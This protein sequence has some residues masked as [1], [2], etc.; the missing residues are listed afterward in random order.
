M[1]WRKKRGSGSSAIWHFV[2]VW[3][4]H[5][6]FIASE[7]NEHQKC[8]HKITNERKNTNFFY[9]YIL[10]CQEK[11]EDEH[12][13]NGNLEPEASAEPY[14]ELCQISKME[15]FAKIVNCFY[16]RFILDV[17]QAYERASVNH[18]ENTGFGNSNIK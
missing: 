14:A 16:Q 7:S 6:V 13:F 5:C 17:C 18:K 8:P 15:S 10:L 9:W 11:Y 3:Q 1:S 12:L 2:T 4:I